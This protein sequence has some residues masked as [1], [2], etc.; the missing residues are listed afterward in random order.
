MKDKIR[1]IYLELQG[2]LKELPKQETT[3]SSIRS[4]GVWNSYHRAIEELNS[5]TGKNY[6]FAKVDIKKAD[7]GFGIPYFVSLTEFRLKLGG[8]ISRLY[9]EYFSDEANPLDGSPTTLITN[10]QNQSQTLQL[11]IVLEISAL[12]GKKIDTL[13]EGSKEKKFFEQIKSGLTTSKGV[14]GLIKDILLTGQNLG[15]S[16]GEILKLFS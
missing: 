12:I 14:V 3:S 9:A 2:F 8:V 7:S 13:E 16:I 1:P 5:I 10:S 4:E 6:D 11:E 15:I